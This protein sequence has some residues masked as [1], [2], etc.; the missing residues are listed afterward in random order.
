MF[1]LKINRSISFKNKPEISIKSKYFFRV[2]HLV[3]ETF[4]SQVF[5]A[6]STIILEASSVT[7]YNHLSVLYSVQ[8]AT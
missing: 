8:A 3:R 1:S 2:L 4:M 6:I 7:F 5:E